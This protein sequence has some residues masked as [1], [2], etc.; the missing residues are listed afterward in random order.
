MKDIVTN[1]AMTNHIQKLED[2]LISRVENQ[3]KEIKNR[4]SRQN[5]LEGRVA[6]LENLVKLRSH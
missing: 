1:E 2:K 4:R 5:E 3:A 6:V